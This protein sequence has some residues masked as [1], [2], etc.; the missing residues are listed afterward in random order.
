MMSNTKRM[1]ARLALTAVLGV[2]A[3]GLGS[4]DRTA[5]PGDQAPPTALTASPD[6]IRAHMAFLADDLLDGRLAGTRSHAIA[7]RYVASQ[8]AQAGLKPGAGQQ[9]WFQSVPIVESTAVIP[10][11]TLEFRSADGRRSVVLKPADD[12]L[13]SASAS[14]AE[15]DASAPVTFVGFGVVAPERG[16][17]DLAGIDLKGRVALMLDGAPA[18]FPPTE[19]AHHSSG[20]TK[21]K[22]LVERGAVG[23]VSFSTPEDAKRN[24]W[25][26]AVQ[27]SWRPRMRWI[28]A[29]GLPH[30]AFP[31]L[32]IRASLS[33]EAAARLFAAG[34][35]RTL[36]QVFA[37]AAAGTPQAFELP[38]AVK[39]LR[40]SVIGR[41]T[42]DNVVGL[43]DGS[44]PNL[45]NQY[46]VISAHLDHVGR[47]APVNGDSIYNGAFDNASGVAVM[48]EAARLLAA[49][50]QRP[51]RSVLFVAVTAEEAGLVGS[52]YFANN[53]P[54][55]RGEMVANVNM[56]MPV[57]ITPAADVIAY[58][59]EHSNLGAMAERAARAEGVELTPD[60]RP[61]ETF[62][63]RSDQYSFVRR[64][65]PALYIT[66][67]RKS[68]DPLRN[69]KA[70]YDAFMKD[71]Y[72][73]PSDDLSQDI[74]YASLAMLARLNVRIIEE[75]A[76]SDA[77]P[78]WNAG[79]FFGKTFAAAP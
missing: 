55:G 40:R 75:I 76:R 47:G 78:A 67:G 73:Q 26:R 43:L 77:R 63:V 79:N 68:R 5:T 19:R 46:I 60:D 1:H 3:F 24:P 69:Q 28:G 7:A 22:N 13:P 50:P 65:V 62:F 6:A 49:A 64:G 45:R 70:L 48:L 30:D 8:M 27:Q 56:D 51:R 42:S 17:D 20:L 53:P 58:G 52:D 57:M 59:A 32:R 35:P 38:L 37:A 39:Q 54:I 74:D 72:H 33:P 23:V 10:P 34:A 14:E 21:L 9:Q 31:E 41:K 11:A 18:S 71:R 16:H 61:E 36:E 29:N 44:D 25:A 15:I 4:C 66:E 12:F 2:A